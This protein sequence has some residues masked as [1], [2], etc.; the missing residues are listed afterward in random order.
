MDANTECTTCGAEVEWYQ[1]DGSGVLVSLDPGPIVYVVTGK[2]PEGG[3]E[4]CTSVSGD[5]MVRHACPP[6]SGM[7]DPD[8]PCRIGR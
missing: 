2:G 3:V 7:G 6:E 5:Y 1:L 4:R 8:P